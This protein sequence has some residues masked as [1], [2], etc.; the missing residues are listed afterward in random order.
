MI[1]RTYTRLIAGGRASK[2]N[3]TR[4]LPEAKGRFEGGTT[5]TNKQYRFQPHGAAAASPSAI[6]RI[7]RDNEFN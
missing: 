4:S 2:G 6:L 1:S 3:E 5:P 7:P